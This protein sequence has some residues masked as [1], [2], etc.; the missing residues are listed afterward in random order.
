MSGSCGSLSQ[1]QSETTMITLL[2]HSVELVLVLL[3]ML[4]ELM[5]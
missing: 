4:D 2:I 5:R 3:D 1:L